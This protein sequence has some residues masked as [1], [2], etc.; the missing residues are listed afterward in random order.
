MSTVTRKNTKPKACLQRTTMTINYQPMH[1]QNP[2][3]RF[4]A[5]NTAN[6]INGVRAS[7]RLYVERKV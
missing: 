2:L 3:V 1:V 6:R 4:V 7:L 5:D